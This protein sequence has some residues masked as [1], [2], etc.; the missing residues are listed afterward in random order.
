[1]LAA[2][3]NHQAAI[4]EALHK[5]SAASLQGASLCQHWQGLLDSHL[6]QLLLLGAALQ[7]A[8]TCTTQ[9]RPASRAA[10]PTG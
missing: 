8:V 3:C 7:V 6:R 2:T 9:A 1:M 10:R 4:I 5:E